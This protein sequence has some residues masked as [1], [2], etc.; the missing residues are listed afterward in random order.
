MP[1]VCPNDR[2]PSS[3]SRQPM[4][5]MAKLW[6]SFAAGSISHQGALASMPRTISLKAVDLQLSRNWSLA[7]CK[8]PLEMPCDSHCPCTSHPPESQLRT[9]R[10]D[11]DSAPILTMASAC[12]TS[13]SAAQKQHAAQHGRSSRMSIMHIVMHQWKCLQHAGMQSVCSTLTCCS[14]LGS[15][16][17]CTSICLCFM[18]CCT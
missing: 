17:A 7:D 5:S 10:K 12:I 4:L 13:W 1:Q 9:V 8:C 16:D 18:R 2:Y 11:G 3:N 14:C 6:R 15:C